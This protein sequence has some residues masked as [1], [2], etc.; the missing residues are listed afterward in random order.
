MAA[1]P[2]AASAEDYVPLRGRSRNP[3]EAPA[4]R[5]DGGA[6]LSGPRSRVKGGPVKLVESDSVVKSRMPHHTG[7]AGNRE[8]RRIFV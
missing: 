4:R 7:T 6:P 2:T 5:W 3:M 1:F 8:Q